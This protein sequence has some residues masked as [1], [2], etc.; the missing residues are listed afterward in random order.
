MNTGSGAAASA[1]TE[2]SK[3]KYDDLADR[4]EEVYFYVADLGERLIDRAD[5]APGTRVL[6]IGAGR[7]AVARA[8][9]AKGCAVTAVDVSPRMVELLAADLPQ[10]AVHCMEAGR[11]GFPDGA[12]DLVTAGFVLQILDEPAA[13]LAEIRRVLTPGG[14]V[15][16]SVDTQS[17]GRLGWL[18]ELTAEFFGSGGGRAAT[19]SDR[20]D[21]L[22]ARAGF[23]DIR[24]ETVTV[25]QPL[26]D[27]PALWDWMMPRGL[28][29]IL[30]TLPASRAEDFRQAFMTHAEQMHRAD[31]GIVL[32]FILT[33]HLAKAPL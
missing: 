24:R 29:E 7:G 13:A 16:L 19:A 14:T 31:D 17:I 26:P 5:P 20:T 28:T 3:R 1:V 32:D 10:I 11:L 22:L 33:L 23:T 6:D 12:F 21:D 15:A 4:Y 8:A 27:P 18:P 9:L 30:K 2:Q 25:L